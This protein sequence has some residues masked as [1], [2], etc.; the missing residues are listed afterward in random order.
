M[1]RNG[2]KNV[3]CQ[4]RKRHETVDEMEEQWNDY[5][6]EKDFVFPARRKGILGD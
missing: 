4:E 3:A 6:T 5:G 2:E 1:K